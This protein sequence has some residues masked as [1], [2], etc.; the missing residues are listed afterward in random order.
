MRRVAWPRASGRY[1]R[2]LSSASSHAWGR[3]RRYRCLGNGSDDRIPPPR[4]L[5]NVPSPSRFR[6]NYIYSSVPS[7]GSARIIDGSRRRRVAAAAVQCTAT[8][9]LFTA[10]TAFP[11]TLPAGY[12]TDGRYRC[13]VIRV[14]PTMGT[15]FSKF[16]GSLSFF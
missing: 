1:R 6:G 13:Q 16:C 9:A 15:Y 14:Y 10:R 11:Y 3:R 12:R 7:R 8:T 2:R 4:E 5:G